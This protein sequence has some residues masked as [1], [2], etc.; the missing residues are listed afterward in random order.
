M[1]AKELAI[2]EAYGKHWDSNKENIDAE[3]WFNCGY[4]T[5]GQEDAEQ[6]L[7]DYEIPYREGNFKCD[8]EYGDGWYYWQPTLL[9]GIHGNNNWV[10]I[11]SENDLPIK[12]GSYFVY[13]KV[14]WGIGYRIDIFT[15]RLSNAINHETRE[16]I[17][18]HY[19]EI[20]KPKPPIY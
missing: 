6:T 16:P 15:G 18:S 12:E 20:I 14:D 5:N 13:S 8:S 11:E 17:F 7:I 3:G 9:K 2:K 1:T 10:K 19:Q 4:C